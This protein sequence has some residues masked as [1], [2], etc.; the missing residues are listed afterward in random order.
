MSFTPF[1]AFGKCPKE[2]KRQNLIY[3]CPSQFATNFCQV[4]KKVLTSK[5]KV[6]KFISKVPGSVDCINTG[7]TWIL[8]KYGNEVF[9]SI[10]LQLSFY[11][12]NPFIS[13][14]L[15]VVTMASLRRSG[16]RLSSLGKSNGDLKMV[17]SQLKTVRENYVAY[18][19]AQVDRFLVRKR[20]WNWN[21]NPL[22]AGKSHGWHD[23]MGV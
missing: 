2:A 16:V 11:F 7:L 19:K 9:L 5:H 22:C 6:S 13:D 23:Q 15:I 20:I 4:A 8:P 12:Q 18:T 14:K 17:I 10:K 3:E 21:L 1:C